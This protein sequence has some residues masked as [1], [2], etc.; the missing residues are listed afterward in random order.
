MF[1]AGTIVDSGVH[2][3]PA[4]LAKFGSIGLVAWIITAF[5]AV[6]LALIFAKMGA[7]LPATGGPYAYAR[8]GFVDYIEL[9]KYPP[10]NDHLFSDKNISTLGPHRFPWHGPMPALAL[11]FTPS[12]VVA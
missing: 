11:R 12:R 9:K 8:A 3:L 6:F 7:I 1:V 5:G 2:M 10:L 4:S